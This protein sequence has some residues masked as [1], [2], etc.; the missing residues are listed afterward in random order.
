MEQPQGFGGNTKTHG[1]KGRKQSMSLGSE[2]GPSGELSHTWRIGGGARIEC[3]LRSGLCYLEGSHFSPGYCCRVRGRGSHPS[4]PLRHPFPDKTQQ[5]RPG[6][7]FPL[8]SPGG[9]QPHKDLAQEGRAA[10]LKLQ[11]ERHLGS[12]GVMVYSSS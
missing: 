6:R 10:K 2:Q 7:K 4:P 1:R 5:E 8:F 12:Y 3:R 11:Q 9:S